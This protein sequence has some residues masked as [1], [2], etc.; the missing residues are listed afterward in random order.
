MLSSSVRNKVTLALV[1]WI[2]A[3]SATAVSGCVPEKNTPKRPAFTRLVSPLERAIVADSL[4]EADLM[5][6]QDPL[7][8]P[9]LVDGKIVV[10]IQT[11]PG[12]AEVATKAVTRVGGEVD[13]SG[14]I[15]ERDLVQAVL[16]ISK[17]TIL[18]REESIHTIRL[19]E[20]PVPQS[21]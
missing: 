21:Q 14:T 4:G 9:W 18:A 1:F 13:P 12:Q 17:L 10:I 6:Q 20:P 7:F 19:P 11:I 2:A 15:I 5:A 16:P 8:A 3:L